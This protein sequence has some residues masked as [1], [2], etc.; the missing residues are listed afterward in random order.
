MALVP[1]RTKAAELTGG[2]AAAIRRAFAGRLVGVTRPNAMAE[3]A[4]VTNVDTLP[5]RDIAF[6]MGERRQRPTEYG[7]CNFPEA[8]SFG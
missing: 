3:S 7:D 2:G 1:Q 4:P 6:D 8:S 5:A